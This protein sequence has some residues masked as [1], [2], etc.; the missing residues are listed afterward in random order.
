M[1]GYEEILEEIRRVHGVLSAVF[2]LITDAEEHNVG[3]VFSLQILATHIVV[4]N[5]VEAAS[6]LLETRS[7]V[8]SQRIPTTMPKL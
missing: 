8:Y 3:P 4:V 1:G 2:G 7:S 6:E 5:T